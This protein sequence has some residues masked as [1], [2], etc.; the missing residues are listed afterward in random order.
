MKVILNGGWVETEAHTL[1]QLVH[2]LGYGG[3]K[4]AAAVNGKFVADQSYSS[5]ALD[6][7]AEIEIVAPMQGG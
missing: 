5:I 6:E 2:N 3:K 1:E 4:I 7:G